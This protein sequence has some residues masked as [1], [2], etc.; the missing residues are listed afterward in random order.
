MKRLSQL[1]GSHIAL[2]LL[3]VSL[4]GQRI[5]HLL[6]VLWYPLIDDFVSS[7]DGELRGALDAILGDACS[8]SA[9]LQAVLPIRLGGLGLQEPL[10]VHSATYISSC[11]AEA[12][13]I[14]SVDDAE[15][16]P[17]EDFWSTT[18]HLSGLLCASDTPLPEWLATH[19]NPLLQRLLGG[20]CIH[21]NSGRVYGRRRMQKRYS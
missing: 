20:G 19:R 14:F 13:C 12:A 8:D 9:W 4:G 6:R 5:S 2:G 17:A 16:D 11:L 21:R 3:R 1:P 18:G 10:Q 15:V 7:T